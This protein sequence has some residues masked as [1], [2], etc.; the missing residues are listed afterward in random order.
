MKEILEARGIEYQDQERYYTHCPECGD[1]RQK[2]GTKTLSVSTSGGVLA[3][4]CLHSDKCPLH[5]TKILSRPMRSLEARQEQQT[6]FIYIPEDLNIPAPEGSIKYKYCNTNGDILYYV[7]RTTDKKFYPMSLTEDGELVAKK[8]NF[9]TLYGAE[10]LHDDDRPVIVVE[11]EKTAEAAREIFKSADVVTWSGGA[12]N[13]TSQPWELI[14]NR[15]IIL[16]PDND[17]A[18]ISAMNKL[19]NILD[20]TKISIINTSELDPKMDLADDL[21]LD[22]IKKLYRERNQLKQTLIPNALSF[23]NFLESVTQ[24]ED[25]DPFGFSNIDKVMRMPHSGLIIVE[26]RSGHGKSV[27][28]LNSAIR[29][30]RNTSRKVVIVSYEVPAKAAALRM[31]MAMEGVEKSSVMFENERLYLEDLAAGNLK[32]QEELQ[33]YLNNRLWITEEN[34]SLSDLKKYL[35]TSKM[36]NAVIYLDYIQLIPHTHQQT[37]YLAIKDIADT[38]REIA[39]RRNQIIMTGSQLTDGE[40][41]YQDV[42]REGRDITNAS[43]ITLKV[44]NKDVASSQE[45]MK[46]TK[47]NKEEVLQHYYNN[48]AGNFAVSVKK[49]RVGGL[50][51][52]FGFNL[53]YGCLLTEA[54]SSFKDF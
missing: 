7:V 37:R 38:L 51:R 54:E 6:R 49:S 33:G 43:E 24:R 4:K 36:E 22:V 41:P 31:L 1:K 32:T 14:A 46:K 53:L 11:G 45:I 26:G 10:L 48:A 9:K 19:A 23:N 5:E 30:L 12:S 3:I 15:E 34:L 2:V 29:I 27:F 47:E 42:A 25:R 39:N 17:D 8:P 35:D 44:W 28:M 13:V 16:W 50:G 40:T 52:T 20:S 21:P 18:G